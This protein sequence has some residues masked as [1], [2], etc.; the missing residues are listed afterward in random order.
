MG[1]C[2]T[3]GHL[4]HSGTR[5]G[6]GLRGPLGA[7]RAALLAYQAHTMASIDYYKSLASYCRQSYFN[8][9]KT[10]ASVTIKEKMHWN[11]HIPLL[12]AEFEKGVRRIRQGSPYEYD[13]VTNVPPGTTKST[14]FSVFAVPWAWTVFPTLRFIG[15]S[16]TDAL[17]LELSN[18]SRQI[19]E[20]P[21]YR[22]L[23]PEIELRKDTNMKGHWANTL[24]GDR[25]SCTVSGSV[26]GMHGHIISIDDPIDPLGAKSK[27]ELLEAVA[28]CGETIS[29]RKVD[30]TLSMTYL[31][32]QRLHQGDPSNLFLTRGTPV[33]HYC[34]PG[35]LTPG[36]RPRALR[37]YYQDGML[38]PV[39]MPM[40]VLGRMELELGQYGYAGQVLQTPIPPAGGMFQTV[41]LL[42]RVRHPPP[43]HEFT[44]IVRFWDKAITDGSGCYTC[45]VLMGLHRTGQF[46]VLDVRR[47]QWGADEREQFISATA[48]MDGVGVRIYMEEE[49]GSAGKL[50]SLLSI[51]ALAGY[52]IICQRPR[53]SK[54]LRADTY[55]SQVNAGNVYLAT[56]T[57][58]PAYVDELAFFPNSLYADQVDASGGAFGN[59]FKP[60]TKLGAL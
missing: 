53:G 49:G 54:V 21:L 25:Y 17:S 20:S 42:E 56:G 38:D 43:R 19:V 5:G 46:W 26:T 12:C 51:R 23:F 50:D 34:L 52:R 45:G 28:W 36:V 24:G 44:R 14:I 47:G 60:G 2:P 55:S 57:W 8:F 6:F 59:L 16:Y 37:Q 31:T 32:M 30:K 58:V 27:A 11:W 15:G 33:K 40:E 9:L 4:R 7:H 41:K 29:Q 18:K 10:F 13:V 39:R 22:K 48:K 35:V 3:G 1:T